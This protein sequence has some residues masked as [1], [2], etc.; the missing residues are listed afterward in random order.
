MFRLSAAHRTRLCT[1]LFVTASGL[2]GVT[3][4]VRGQD[5]P[6][7]AATSPESPPA[8]Q[9]PAPTSPAE[10][11][12]RQIEQLQSQL[13][14]ATDLEDPVRKQIQDAL[15]QATK[16]LEAAVEH[17]TQTRSLVEKATSL[18]AEQKSLAERIAELKEQP[19]P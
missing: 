3:A 11:L 19:E 12:K 1:I 5:P 6:A 10:T 13:D 18:E 15:T 17:E 14:A 16:E 8:T 4:A 7:D 2:F 9:E